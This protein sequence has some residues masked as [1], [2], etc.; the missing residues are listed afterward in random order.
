MSLTGISANRLELL[1]I[2]EAVAREKSIDKEIVIEAIEEA[3][4]KG[5]RARYGAEHDIRVSIDTK[6]GEMII[7]RVVTVVADDATFGMVEGDDGVELPAEEPAGVLRPEEVRLAA[8]PEV[9]RLVQQ[10]HAP[11]R[12]LDH[13]VVQQVSVG[14]RRRISSGQCC[15]CPSVRIPVCRRVAAALRVRVRFGLGHTPP[16][17]RLTTLLKNVSGSSDRGRR[18]RPPA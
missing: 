9:P 6:T 16:G 14:S 17:V 7:K 11:E 15:V 3:I 12:V 5:A 4:Q 1:Q 18:A 2:A 13:R 8:E 10:L